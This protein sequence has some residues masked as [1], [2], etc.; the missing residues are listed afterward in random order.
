MLAL[1]VFAFVLYSTKGD[2]PYF[3]CLT[4][5]INPIIG[6]NCQLK[7]SNQYDFQLRNQLR[8][9]ILA[10]QAVAP[11]DIEVIQFLVLSCNFSMA[12]IEASMIPQRSYPPHVLFRLWPSGLYGP[13]RWDC[14]TR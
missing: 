11:D 10:D 12:L 2:T 3:E 13:A 4:S 9:V 7:K 8:S 1:Q 6:R 5:E 14:T